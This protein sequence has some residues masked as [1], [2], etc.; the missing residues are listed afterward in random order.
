[1]TTVTLNLDEA[2]VKR[3]QDWAARSGRSLEELVG[4]VLRTSMPDEE[5][6]ATL[7]PITRSLL[8]I[9]PPTTDAERTQIIEDALL[10]KRNRQ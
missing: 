3:A 2:V 6:E 7:G 1:M 9:A 5:W 8:G 10:E 4:D